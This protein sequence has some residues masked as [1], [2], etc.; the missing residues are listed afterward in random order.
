MISFEFENFGRIK[1]LISRIYKN[2]HE[3]TFALFHDHF[4]IFFND[5]IIRCSQIKYI[6]STISPEGLWF[7][8]VSQHLHEAMMHIESSNQCIFTFNESSLF[9]TTFSKKTNLITKKNLKTKKTKLHVVLCNPIHSIDHNNDFQSRLT[10]LTDKIEPRQFADTSTLLWTLE[11]FIHCFVDIQ[12]VFTMNTMEIIGT[13]E[14]YSGSSILNV[15]NVN[16]GDD[17]L[18]L[19]IQNTINLIWL[20]DFFNNKCFFYLD[21][22]TLR[23]SLYAIEE[24]S[25]FSSLL[26]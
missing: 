2:S 17:V 11:K 20:A 25:C 9:I 7:K 16:I 18:S 23:I 10:Y 22:Q 21:P 19:N 13:H 14:E 1:L 6:D 4:M 15:K 24:N 5:S 12:I 8:I 3:I 26:N